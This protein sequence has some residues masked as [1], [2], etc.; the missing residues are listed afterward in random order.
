[1]NKKLR[2]QRKIDLQVHTYHSDGNPEISLDDILELATKR[3]HLSG[4]AITDHDT[5]EGFCEASEKATKYGIEVYSGVEISARDIPE[6]NWFDIHILGYLFNPNHAGLN[7]V[8]KINQ[9]A[10]RSRV[11]ELIEKSRRQG[12]TITIEEVKV[13]AGKRKPRTADV[14]RVLQKNNPEKI[15]NIEIAFNMIKRG[16]PLYVFEPHF[17]EVSAII[18]EIKHA[19]GISV[20]AHPEVYGEVVGIHREGEVIIKEGTKNLDYLLRRMKREGIDGIEVI[21]P[22]HTSLISK[23]ATKAEVLE[24]KEIPFSQIRFPHG[25]IKGA[26]L[27]DR[28]TTTECAK[29]I[30]E[31]Y[32]Q[33][34]R[35][36]RLLIS[37]GSDFHGRDTRIEL[38]NGD[39]SVPERVIL[40]MK[41]YLTRRVGLEVV[42]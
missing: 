9:E 19:G 33:F 36:H 20:L 16:G 6:Q 8:L 21:Y 29:R 10:R 7:Q 23:I 32:A 39:F 25:T 35:H 12:Y 37:G 42:R 1:M 24:L 26:A 27:R 4:I 41:C 28:E 13:L 3:Y 34:A 31:K 30:N 22:Y 18:Q 5:L 17:M 14:A 38:S 11:I 15:P 40:D 2:D